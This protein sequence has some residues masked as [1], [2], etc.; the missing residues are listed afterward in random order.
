MAENQ[1]RETMALR[2]VKPTWHLYRVEFGA[3]DYKEN[4]QGNLIKRVQRDP[5]GALAWEEDYYFSGKTFTT[6]KGQVI[7]EQ[8]TVHCDYGNAMLEVNYIGE[9]PTVVELLEKVKNTPS[10]N[11]KLSIADQILKKWGTSRL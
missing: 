8:L 9:D 5:K 6:F 11:E 2:L 7:S 4:L 10:A 1:Q 3:E